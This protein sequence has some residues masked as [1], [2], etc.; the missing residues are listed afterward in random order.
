MLHMWIIKRNIQVKG[1]PL[2]GIF[3]SRYVNKFDKVKNPKMA[4]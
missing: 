2:E 3:E 4:S 1:I